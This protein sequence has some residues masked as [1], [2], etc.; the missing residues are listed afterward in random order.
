[1]SSKRRQRKVCK[2]PRICRD[3][4]LQKRPR[5]CRNE[6]KSHEVKGGQLSLQV[7]LWL[8]IRGCGGCTARVRL[9]ACGKAG[10]HLALQEFQRAAP[11]FLGDLETERKV[12]LLSW[13]TTGGNGLLIECYHKA[14]MEIRYWVLLVWTEYSETRPARKTDS[15]FL[16]VVQ[17]LPRWYLKTKVPS[18]VF[19]LIC[20]KCYKLSSSNPSTTGTRYH[21]TYQLWV[22]IFTCIKWCP[23]NME[24]FIVVWNVYGYFNSMYVC[25]P[26]ACLAPEAT[27]DPL[28]LE[29]FIVVRWEIGEST[30]GLVYSERTA[31]ALNY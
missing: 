14:T 5:N 9:T 1:M 8:G 23:T 18:Q 30:Q 7:Y 26:W 11:F 29:L 13:S 31:S 16:S 22:S 2:V 27:R 15:L 19:I 25:A 12:A 20:S 17:L 21:T 6:R 4:H 3:L 24:G 10:L 28:E